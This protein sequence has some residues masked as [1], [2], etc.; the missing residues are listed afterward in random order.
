MV[1]GTLLV[2][3]ASRFTSSIFHTTIRNY[4]V[5]GDYLALLFQQIYQPLHSDTNI[6]FVFLKDFFC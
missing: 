6:K 4:V 2:F 5:C 1:T 3:S